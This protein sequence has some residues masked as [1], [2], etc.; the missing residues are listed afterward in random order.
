MVS[1]S[2]KHFTK[3]DG[4]NSKE[5]QADMDPYLDEM[6]MEDVILDN[7]IENH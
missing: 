6:Q 5:E 7:K 3:Y 1:M 4:V 2:F